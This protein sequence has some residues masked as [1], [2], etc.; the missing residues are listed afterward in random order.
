M[1]RVRQAEAS[2]RGVILAAPR[3]HAKSTLFSFLYPLW[4]AVYQ[5]RRFIVI[6]SASGTQ[7]MLFADAIKKELEQNALLSEDFGPLVGADYAMQWSAEDLLIVH[8]RR[9]PDGTVATDDRGHPLAGSTVR[10]VSRGNGAS[11]RGLR[12]RADRPDLIIADDLETDEHV[13]TPAQR[14]KLQAWWYRA[15]EPMADPRR[16][17]VVVVGTILH[18]DSLLAHLLARTDVYDTAT[19]RAIQED[20]TPLWPAKWPLEQLEAMRQRIGSL[21]FAQEY[22]NEPLDPASQVFHPEWWRWWTREEVAF[23][24]AADTWTYQGEPLALYMAFDPALGRGGDESAVAV[25]GITPDHRCVVLALEHGQWEFP[26]QVAQLTR[27]TE[28]WQPRVLGIEAVAYQ[29]ALVQHLRGQLTVP[30]R[31]IKHGRGQSKDATTG[32]LTALSPY[33]EA[34]RVLLRAATD[35]EPG[36]LIPEIGIRVHAGQAALFVQATQ[37]PASAHDDQLDALEMAV[38]T[39]RVR[40]FFDTRGL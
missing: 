11:V 39:A 21:H 34:G 36:T 1:A 40:R 7:A 38:D 9:C 16:G 3:L 5:R 18:H 2:H 15:V 25:V 4:C 29:E 8:P 33:V 6:L 13:G 19:F 32:R 10:L 20:G 35:T 23:D 17:Q 28:E 31:A 26:Q 27:L 37:Y 14:E 12:S 22:L 30:I 24:E